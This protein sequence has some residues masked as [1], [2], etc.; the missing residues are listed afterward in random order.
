MTAYDKEEAMHAG[1]SQLYDDVLVRQAC[2]TY[3]RMCVDAQV[4]NIK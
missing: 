2:N 1:P 4:K 3:I